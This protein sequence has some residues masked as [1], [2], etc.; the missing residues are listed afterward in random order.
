MNQGTIWVLL[1]QKNRRRK[2]HAWA[3]LSM[4]LRCRKV[5][6]IRTQIKLLIH[7][8][9]IRRHSQLLKY[10]QVWKNTCSDCEVLTTLTTATFFG[11]NFIPNLCAVSTTFW[12]CH[13]MWMT[14]DL[15]PH[16]NSTELDFLA[17]TVKKLHKYLSKCHLEKYLWA[18]RGLLGSLVENPGAKNLARRSFNLFRST[19]QSHRILD[20][21]SG[22]I[23]CY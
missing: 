21:I 16:N 18:S 17:S 14:L 5:Q 12:N 1:M 7:F 6:F 4:N 9:E 3:P 19:V 22:S 13:I 15:A 11:A 23:K 20:Y 10:S 8:W 2:S